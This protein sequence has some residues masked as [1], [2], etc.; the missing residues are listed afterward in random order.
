ME[1]FVNKIFFHTVAVSET[2]MGET[3]T[4]S[5]GYFEVDGCADD[6]FGDPDPFIRV[7]SKCGTAS[8]HQTDTTVRYTFK[9]LI[10][11]F[12]L[13]FVDKVGVISTEGDTGAAAGTPRNHGGDD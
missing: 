1:F 9:P 7:F 4:D 11:D 2:L 3:R 10:N 5:K 6:W 8:I 12:G 13:I